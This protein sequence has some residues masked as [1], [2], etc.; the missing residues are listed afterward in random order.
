MSKV[1]P[2]QPQEAAATMNVAAKTVLI[3]GS[4]DGVGRRMAERFAKEGVTVLIHGRDR[5]RADRLQREI[6]K[7][8]SSAEIRLFG[9]PLPCLLPSSCTHRRRP[10]TEL[11][12][13]TYASSA[14]R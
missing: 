8:G 6:R 7:V 5:L 10:M 11:H 9:N 14:F 3:T 4:A 2:V 1:R 12:E 13:S